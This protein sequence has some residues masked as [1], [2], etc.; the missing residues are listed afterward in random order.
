MTKTALSGAHFEDPILAYLAKPDSA[1]LAL[2]AGVD[3]PSYRPSV[4]DITVLDEKESIGTL[5]SGCVEADIG[6]HATQER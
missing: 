2:M 6:V 4:A 5:S 3:G 1:V